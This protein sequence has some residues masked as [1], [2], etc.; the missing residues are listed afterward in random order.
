VSGSKGSYSLAAFTQDLK[1]Q[2]HPLGIRVTVSVRDD[3]GTVVTAWR[4]DRRYARIP[5][6]VPTRRLSPV[7]ALLVA[8]TIR[9]AYA[10]GSRRR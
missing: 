9:D 6:T 2:L 4:Q 8:R 1:R 3:R 5:F 7:V 10:R